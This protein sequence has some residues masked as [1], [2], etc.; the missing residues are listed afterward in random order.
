MA[1][2]KGILGIA[3]KC[4]GI[5]PGKGFLLLASDEKG[6]GKLGYSGSFKHMRKYVYFKWNTH[7]VKTNSVSRFMVSHS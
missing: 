2:L 1:A 7:N 3:D 6:H 4:A 5:L